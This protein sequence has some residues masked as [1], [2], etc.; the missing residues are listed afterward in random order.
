MRT[1]LTSGG[2]L[3]LDIGLALFACSASGQSTVKAP[4]EIIASIADREGSWSRYVF[5]SCGIS[6]KDERDRALATQLT[7]EGPP[8]IVQLEQVFDSL[9][10]RG[11]GS[12]YFERPDW[13]FLAYAT[14]LGPASGERLRAMIADP[15]LVNLQVDLDRALAVSFGVTSYI[16]SARKWGPGDLCRRPEPRDALDEL[17]TAIEQGD[18]SRL[19]RALG[20]AA[21]AA[22]RQTQ[23]ERSWEDFRRAVWRIPPSGQSA[24]GYLFDIRGR[25]SEPEQVLEGPS[26]YHRDYG[27]APVLADDF[28][29][30][31][32]F[33]ANNGND[34]GTHVVD[35][36]A[37]HDGLR[38]H[39]QVNNEDLDALIRLIDSCFVQ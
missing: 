10:A 22:L 19:Q 15:R 34:C 4:S 24:V 32:N 12:P 7:R 3:L 16:S 5:S 1:L 39:Y 31:A 28:E 33:R 13:F 37:V 35:F 25:W 9:Q 18:F 20:P 27:D 21:I 6:A 23:G 26:R 8:A 11:T 38:F 29:L 17:I 14:M 2:L 36:H 30:V